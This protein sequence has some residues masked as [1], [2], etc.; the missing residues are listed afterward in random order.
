MPAAEQPD[1]ESEGATMNPAL[2][3]LLSECRNLL[4]ATPG[5]K[6]RVGVFKIDDLLARDAAHPQADEFEVTFRIEPDGTA[7]VDWG[8]L[9]GLKATDIKHFQH[10][11]ETEWVNW[12][13][14]LLDA[15]AAE[16]P[17]TR[18]CEEFHR[19]NEEGRR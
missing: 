15:I 2:R 14:D 4:A 17:R 11:V 5:T 16:E 3:K 9:E 7:N 18:D 19:A 10:R 13:P 1:L 12:A 8:D 6:F